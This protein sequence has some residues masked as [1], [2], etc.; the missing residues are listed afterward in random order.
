MYHQGLYLWTDALAPSSQYFFISNYWTK[1]IFVRNKYRL[2]LTG[3][4]DH[5]PSD[6]RLPVIPGG[7]E[8]LCK[9]DAEIL[10]VAFAH[11]GLRGASGDQCAL[12]GEDQSWASIEIYAV[13]GLVGGAEGDGDGLLQTSGEGKVHGKRKKNFHLLEKGRS[14]GNTSFRYTVDQ[15]KCN[16]GPH[17][18]FNTLLEC[19]KWR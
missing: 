5:V 11:Q 10:E 7:L 1:H 9:A 15:W 19:F 2:S 6:F 13:V 14:V 12:D 4:H 17:R 3:I 16:R 8:A 18:S